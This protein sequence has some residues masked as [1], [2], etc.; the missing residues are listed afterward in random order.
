MARHRRVGAVTVAGVAVLLSIASAAWACTV[1]LGDITVTG[2]GAGN[3]SLTVD[4]EGM[5]VPE[6]VWCDPVPHTSATDASQSAYWT[7]RVNG[8]SPSITVSV[9]PN[10]GCS[11]GVGG[12]V[13]TQL[14]AA[15]YNVRILPGYMDED[16]FTNGG[17]H[18]CH[19]TSGGTLLSSSFGVSAGG[20]G[21]ATYTPSSLATGWWSV[22]V[23]HPSAADANAQ[24]FKVV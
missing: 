5:T 24:D 15:S 6:M 20:T 4:A 19:G 3:A 10:D 2:N 16:P 11:G 18:N 22:C 21:S 8:A 14:Q 1:Y 13:G 12:G 9:A 7:A 23:Y 17:P